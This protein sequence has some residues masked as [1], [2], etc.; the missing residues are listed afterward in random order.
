M[1]TLP[2]CQQADFTDTMPGAYMETPRR[3]EAELEYIAMLQAAAG[4]LLATWRL[5]QPEAHSLTIAA[6]V[7]GDEILSGV[8]VR[9]QSGQTLFETRLSHH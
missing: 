2:I 4:A 8:T 6:A 7:V 1:D 9:T 5:Q 3:E